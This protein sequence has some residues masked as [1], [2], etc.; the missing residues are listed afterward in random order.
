MVPNYQIII[1]DLTLRLID[2]E[3]ASKLEN[4]IQ[5]SSSLHQWLDWC[6]VDFSVK[7]AEAF[8]TATRKNWVTAESYGFGVYLRDSNEL[9]GMVA[10]NELYHTFNMA[11]LGYWIADSYQGLGYGKKAV[12]ALIEFCFAQLK[13]TRLE[14]VCDPKN[15]PSQRLIE[16]CGASF[17]TKAK[18]RF[19]FDGKPRE[20][21][22]YSIVPESV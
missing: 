1:A 11:S 19:L 21:L 12:E 4:L 10:I 2:N 20:G 6:R 14:I 18:N 8:I 16:S 9:I 17:E 7:D 3:E 15:L 5:T 22:V 13:L